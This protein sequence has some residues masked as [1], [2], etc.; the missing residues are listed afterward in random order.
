MSRP[1]KPRAARARIGVYKRLEDVPDRHRLSQYTDSY[2]GG[3]V[4][5]E[6]CE[7]HEYTLGDSESFRRKVDRAGE[8]WR[9]FMADRRH[10]ALATPADVEAYSRDLL[11][12]FTMSTAYKYWIRVEHFY[13]WLQWHT[14]HPHVYHPVLMAAVEHDAAGEIWEWK[15]DGVVRMREKRREDG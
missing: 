3:D 7:E 8:L 13:R 10:Y 14:N 1:T 6:F 5:G 12:D 15:R 4:W 11:D 2:A 9:T